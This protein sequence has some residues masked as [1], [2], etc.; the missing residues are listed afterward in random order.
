MASFRKTPC[1]FCGAPAGGRNIRVKS[2]ASLAGA[3]ACV[4]GALGSSRGTVGGSTEAAPGGENI[5]VKSPASATGL[6]T[7]GGSFGKTGLAGGTGLGSFRKTGVGF[8]GAAPAG[9][10][11]G[12][13]PGVTLGSPS[14]APG[15]EGSFGK[16]DGF[17]GAP[18]RPANRR[19]N[20]PGS[21]PELLAPEGSFGKTG[22]FA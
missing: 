22:P 18:G 16:T 11:E 12:V 7:A 1:G 21:S 2:P 15:E 20:S 5:R 17:S 13:T 4:S 14:G 9:R 8:T 10:N 6:F 3:G 19:V